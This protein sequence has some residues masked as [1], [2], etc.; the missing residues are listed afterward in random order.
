MFDLSDDKSIYYHGGRKNGRRV[1]TS[2]TYR[3][4]YIL[5]LEPAEEINFVKV[6]P[7]P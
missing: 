6:N 3:L 1:G 7:L 4:I 2:S 5:N